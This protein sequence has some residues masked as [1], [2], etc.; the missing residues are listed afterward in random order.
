M[1]AEYRP[2]H[3]ARSSPRVPIPTRS[4]LEVHCAFLVLI[5][6]FIAFR[7]IWAFQAILVILLLS[8]PGVILLRALRIPGRLVAS[9][10]DLVDRV[11]YSLPR[12]MGLSGNPRNIVALGPWRN[13]VA[14]VA[15]SPKDRSELPS[16][17]TV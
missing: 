15:D 5:A 14:S 11:L 9:F 4:G 3:A 13:F 17:C 10:P 8:V 7:D 6:F 2:Q 12:Y 1:T 16:S